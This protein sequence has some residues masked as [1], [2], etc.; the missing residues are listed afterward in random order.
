M[1]WEEEKDGIYK[2]HTKNYVLAHMDMK[3][4]SKKKEEKE[5]KEEKRE[6]S[7]K[8]KLENKITKA[9]CIETK[10]DHIVVKM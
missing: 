9:K 5:E 7:I 2:G 1:L 6:N 4:L 10:K 8:E 3:D